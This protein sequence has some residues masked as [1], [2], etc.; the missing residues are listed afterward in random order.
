M[1]ANEAWIEFL[2]TFAVKY[3]EFRFA[4][5]HIGTLDCLLSLADVAR[6]DGYVRP[7]FGLIVFTIAKFPCELLV[8]SMDISDSSV[9]HIHIVN[10]RHPIVDALLVDQ[11]YVPNS[12]QLNVCV[13]A[14]LS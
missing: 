7:I 8:Q 12:T 10:G 13:S 4:I 6:H 3:D 14:V 1:A 2:G 11:Q 5:R 9:P